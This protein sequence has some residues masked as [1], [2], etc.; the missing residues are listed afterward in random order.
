[1]PFKYA[2]PLINLFFKILTR[3][4]KNNL[5]NRLRRIIVR[6]RLLLLGDSEYYEN[7]ILPVKLLRFCGSKYRNNEFFLKSA[8]LETK[9]LM[10]HFRLT[11]QSRIL[12]VGCGVG[13]L[14]IGILNQI[15]EIRSY[16]GIDVDKTAILWC[17]RNVSRHHPNFQFIHLDVKNLRYNPNGKTLPLDFIFPFE[18]NTFDIIYLYS[19]F[20]HMVLEE[21]KTYL[22]EFRRLLSYKGRIFLTVYLEEGIPDMII[23]PEDQKKGDWRGPNYF[24]R[25]NRCFFKKVIEEM[26]FIINLEE[27][28]KIENKQS[29]FYISRKED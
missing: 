29:V 1:L 5:P 25:F 15:G 22:M 12:D 3:F 24:V 8:V 10:K 20:S 13:R 14:A 18:N 19:V 7:S 26:G 17:Q 27:Y 4:P 6:Y 11:S 28:G 23:D 21:I 9:R 16:K 2:L